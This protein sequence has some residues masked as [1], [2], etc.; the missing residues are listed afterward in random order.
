[1]PADWLY[2][3]ANWLYPSVDWL[4]S[5]AHLDSHLEKLPGCEPKVCTAKSQ[6]SIFETQS[7]GK[8][9]GS[10]ASSRPSEMEIG[11]LHSFVIHHFTLP[12]P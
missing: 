4:H 11:K 12:E 8:S 1:M 3:P 5:P 2:P 6:T 7:L 9:G 10:S